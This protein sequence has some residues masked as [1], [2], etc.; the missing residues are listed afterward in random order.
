MRLLLALLLLSAGARAEELTV[1]A[2]A[3]LRESL[4]D[5]AEGFEQQHAGVHVALQFAG[6]QQLR[7]QIENGA[8]ADVFASADEA[9]MAKLG[10]LAPRPAIFAHNEPVLIVP[11]DNPA[12]L[13]VF[14][15][16]PRARSVVLGAVEVPVGAY[17]ARIL[18]AA[19]M[20]I[21]AQVVSRELNVRSVLTK[22][23][24]GEADAG[25]VY[26]TDAISAGNDVRI[27]P[28]PA[29][30][31]VRAGYPIAVLAH[32]PQPA[33]AAQFVELVRSPAGRKALER[34]GFLP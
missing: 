32:A 25:I 4:L 15:D 29:E 19:N 1:F 27:I 28:I 34:F 20:D 10:E 22:V 2:A 33:L 23:A 17:T 24:L 13:T 30:L 3:S 12:G 5:L 18:A 8:R 11:R 7:V 31:N 9:Q 14:R 16:L 26:R 6:S 21:E